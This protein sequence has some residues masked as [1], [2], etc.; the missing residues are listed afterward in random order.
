MGVQVPLPTPL[1]PSHRRARR[2]ALAGRATARSETAPER[3]PGDL[4]ELPLQRLADQLLQDQL[5][6]EDDAARRH[7]A[8]DAGAV[9]A[10]Q[11]GVRVHGRGAVAARDVAEQADELDRRVDGEL[12]VLV[13]RPG[14]RRRGGRSAARRWRAAPPPACRARRRRRRSPPAGRR[15]AAA[16]RRRA[17]RAR[18]SRAPM[19]ASS[20]RRAAGPRAGSP[21]RVYNRGDALPGAAALA[22]PC[23]GQ[24]PRV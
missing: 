22:R 5:A 11:R 12:A 1:S 20:R 15:R 24:S 17:G 18:Y 3:Q 8:A 14:R 10:G 4:V 6:G 2:R 16:G 19:R 7:V 9:V 23:Q 13:G 21:A